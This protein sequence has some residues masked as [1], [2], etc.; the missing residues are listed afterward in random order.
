MK[1]FITLLV[2]GLNTTFLLAECRPA[3][4]AVL[5]SGIDLAHP[6]FRGKLASGYYDFADNDSNPQDFQR[7]TK[8]V[9]W[10][11][12][13]DNWG[14]GTHVAG[15]AL[16]LYNNTSSAVANFSCP[17][18]VMPLKIE[19][20]QV[21]YSQWENGDTFSPSGALAALDHAINQPNIKV[22][23]QSFGIHDAKYI[24]GLI[25]RLENAKRKGIF[26]VQAAGNDGL[27]LDSMMDSVVGSTKIKLKLCRGVRCPKRRYSG[28][29][30]RRS[31]VRAYPNLILVANATKN[32]FA[33]DSNYGKQSVHLA[34]MGDNIFS[35]D[36]GNL[37]PIQLSGTSMSAPKVSRALA[38]LMA[39][40]PNDNYVATLGRL[41]G[42]LRYD[43]LTVRNRTIWGGY[44]P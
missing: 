24:Q 40:Y 22:I 31:L 4:I 3:D 35:T 36:V 42:L 41:K 11:D 14:H 32:Y 16:G 5:D 29:Q 12:S 13:F 26:V 8:N 17:I 25:Y 19:R 9:N 34:T 6:D 20:S 30:L 21:L 38:L 18:R 37:A 33:E 44:L 10:G 15:I 2:L 7:V 39:Q 28:A 23:N 27:D 43:D 1:L